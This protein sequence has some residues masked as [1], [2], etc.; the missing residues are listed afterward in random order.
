MTTINILENVVHG[1]PSGTYD[2]SSLDFSSL[3]VEAADY[4]Q[5]NGSIQTITLRVTGFQGIIRLVATLGD[6]PQQA[7]WFD[8]GEFDYSS[9]AT[10]T[11]IAPSYTGN[12]V[13]VRADIVDFTAGTI[14]FVTITY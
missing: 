9:A 12:F 3:P 10:T 6:D 11:T 8:L 1:V 4:Y 2:G 13:W 5:G 14:N 7:A